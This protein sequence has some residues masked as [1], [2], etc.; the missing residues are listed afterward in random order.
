[1]ASAVRVA[2]THQ[3]KLFGALARCGELIVAVGHV[4]ISANLVGTLR[5][6]R[7]GLEDLLDLDDGRDHVHVD[8]RRVKH[9]EVGVHAGEG[10]LTFY[11]GTET[12]FRV[13]RS[14]G[15]YPSEVARLAVAALWPSAVGEP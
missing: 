6:R 1:M 4:G 12:L 7:H 13:Y 8:W 2:S 11:D 3:R 5:M 9:A 10:L 14:G 15:P